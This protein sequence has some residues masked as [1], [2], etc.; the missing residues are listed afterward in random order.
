MRKIL[1]LMLFLLF[2]VGCSNTANSNRLNENDIMK[3]IYFTETERCGVEWDQIQFTIDL[4]KEIL[5]EI[6]PIETKQYAIEIAKTII[7]GLH[8][9]GKFSEYT[10]VSV[11]HSTED[12]I[13]R[14]EY[15]IDQQ[16]EDVDNLVDCGCLY[17]A[18]DGNKG[19]LIKTWLEE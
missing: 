13:W 8:R 19:E 6:K 15:S 1:P 16:D 5:E 4:D 14:F 7:E 18:I 2:F 10:L 12:N 3:D 9:K 17:V 11:I